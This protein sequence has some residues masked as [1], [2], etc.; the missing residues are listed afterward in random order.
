M[1]EDTIPLAYIYRFPCHIS[2]NSVIRRI[3]INTHKESH[4]TVLYRINTWKS[5]KTPD[6]RSILYNWTNYCIKEFG[7]CIIMKYT[8]VLNYTLNQS[9]RYKWIITSIL[10]VLLKQYRS[11]TDPNKFKSATII[12]VHFLITSKSGT[13]YVNLHMEACYQLSLR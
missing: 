7:K 13:W 11:P 8:Y 4:C 1:S 2:K 6:C 9:H 5:S 10:W 12:S 3:L